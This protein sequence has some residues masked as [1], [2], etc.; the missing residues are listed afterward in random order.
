MTVIL[1]NYEHH[2]DLRRRPTEAESALILKSL[3]WL[4]ADEQSLMRAVYARKTPVAH[5]A[6][7]MGESPV[8]LRR[9]IRAI[10]RRVLS[11]AFQYAALRR[12]RLSPSM[13]RVATSCILHGVSLRD[14]SEELKMSYH[15]ARRHRSVILGLV[16]AE[17]RAPAG[18]ESAW[19][20]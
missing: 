13:R 18:A 4:P 9:R 8:A 19:R 6:R 16:D 3:K 20:V 11:P 1:G 14:A 12:D 17:R 2:V 15:T 5:V 7:L 10:V